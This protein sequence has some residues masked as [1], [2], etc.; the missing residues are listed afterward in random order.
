MR[1]WGYARHSP[2]EN[3]TIDSQVKAIRDYCQEHKHVLVRIFVDEARKGSTVVGRDEFLAMMDAART[4]PLPVDAIVFWAFDRFF[5]GYDRAQFHKAELRLMGYTL[6]SITEPDVPG[7]EGRL[8]EAARDYVAEVRLARLSVNTKRGL[9]WLRDQGCI[10]TGFPPVGLRAKKKA[11]GTKPNGKTRYGRE[12]EPDPATWPLIERA[13]QMRVQGHTLAEIHSKTR[14]FRDA[15]GLSRFFRN[16]AYR[17]AGACTPEEWDAVQAM[18]RPHREGG[19]YPRRKG[20]PYLLS[21]PDLAVLCAYCGGPVCGSVTKYTLKDGTHK[22]WPYYVCA[23]KK[24]RWG[25]CEAKALKQSTVDHAVLST[26]LDQV[27][28]PEHIIDL[29]V[30]VNRI[31]AADLDTAAHKTAA[32]QA[33]LASLDVSISHLLDAVEADGFQ[34]AKDRLEQRRA[35]RATIEV[36]LAQLAQ[37]QAPLLHVD[38]FGIRAAIAEMRQALSPEDTTAAKQALACFVER[39]SLSRDGGEIYYRPPLCNQESLRSKSLPITKTSF[40]LNAELGQGVGVP[41]SK[42]S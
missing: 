41:A 29:V 5:S 37:C 42:L 17:D 39:I 12:W 40:R 28:V 23:A 9:A 8:V 26:V 27:L 22:D 6:I 21:S 33:Q 11:I 18:C 31:L 10:P 38:E 20:S 14:L 15:R 13:W 32:L 4:K 34:A 25:D 3:Q 19:A 2:G 1:V 16:A 30:E 24:R 7:P 35:E 36:E